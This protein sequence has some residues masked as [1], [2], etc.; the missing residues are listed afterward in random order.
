ML[1]MKRK[2]F[3]NLVTLLKTEGGLTRTRNMEVDEMLAMFLV[4]IGHN[5]KNRTCQLLFH[6]SGETVCRT[7]RRVLVAILKLHNLLIAHPVPVPNDCDDERWKVF[8]NCVGAIDGTLVTVRT[9]KASQPRFRTRNQHG[10]NELQSGGEVG[11]ISVSAHHETS[12][13]IKLL[14]HD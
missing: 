12:A 2:I 3:W 8:P 6:R 7:I 1:R 10:Q 13:L 11:D 14:Q 9:T 4:T 5:I